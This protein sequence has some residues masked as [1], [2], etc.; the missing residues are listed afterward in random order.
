LALEKQ[1]IPPNIHFDK[2]NPKI[3]FEGSNMAVPTETVPWPQGRKKRAS[4]NCF[5]IAGA[6][7]HAI[8]ESADSFNAERT[9][10]TNGV[11][12]PEV[13]KPSLL[14][15]SAASENSCL[16]SIVGHEK[17]LQQH[18]SRIQDAV[19]TLCQRKEHLQFR[20]FAVKNEDSLVFTPPRKHSTLKSIIMVFTGQGA[21]W[22]E[23]ASTLLRDYPAFEQDIENMS[24]YL[25][26]LPDP[27]S[28]MNC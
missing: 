28:W 24:G 13:S 27:P 6:N 25:S 15:L 8:L 26:A 12:A 4:V 14:V 23:M 20:S 19:H 21:Q 10:N 5:G 3:H 1:S 18:P 9:K 7:S 11:H 2:P 17:Y 22:A 16:K